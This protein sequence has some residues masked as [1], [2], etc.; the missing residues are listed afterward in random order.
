MPRQR[1]PS[2]AR[3]VPALDR[4][5]EKALRT[6]EI[7]VKR[8]W[9]F[10][11]PNLSTQPQLI[12]AISNKRVPVRRPVIWRNSH[13]PGGSPALQAGNDSIRTVP[14]LRGAPNVPGI[15]PS[16]DWTRDPTAYGNGCDPP[17]CRR[18]QLLWAQAAGGSA[19]ATTA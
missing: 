11:D 5:T 7:S 1:C 4:W 18:R 15:C 2:P 19:T 3:F 12:L 6:V 13:A 14:A 16:G 8:D 10:Q 17:C 9:P